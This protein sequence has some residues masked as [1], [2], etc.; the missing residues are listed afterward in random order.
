MA[1]QAVAPESFVLKSG[2]FK[3]WNRVSV[4]T[5]FSLLNAFCSGHQGRGDYTSVKHL[6]IRS[7]V[8]IPKGK[9][10]RKSSYSTIH[11]RHVRKGG[12]TKITRGRAREDAKTS[13]SSIIFPSST[14][15]SFHTLHKNKLFPSLNRL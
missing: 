15:S 11:R 9:R 8:L 6:T 12:P 4:A 13:V 3:K 10:S 14:T 5:F 1:E 7:D 2:I